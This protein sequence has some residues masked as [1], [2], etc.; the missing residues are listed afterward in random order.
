MLKSE[1]YA[2]GR[3]GTE[4][5]LAVL[6]IPEEGYAK[7]AYRPS[8]KQFSKLVSLW[9]SKYSYYVFDLKTRNAPG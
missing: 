8:S 1:A 5:S 9:Y 7:A 2:F 4:H 3:N 6:D